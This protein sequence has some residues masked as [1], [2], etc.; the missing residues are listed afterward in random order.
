MRFAALLSCFCLAACAG[1]KLPGPGGDS[2]AASAPPASTFVGHSSARP[3]AGGAS[4]AGGGASIARSRGEPIEAHA[5]P[6]I[7]ARS[8]CWMKVEGQKALRGIDQRIAF[9]DK[10]VAERMSGNP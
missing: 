6:L 9:V 7:Q 8:E 4:G 1:G 2:T 3:V 10:C 5:D